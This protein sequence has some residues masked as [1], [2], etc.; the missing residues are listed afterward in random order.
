MQV[1][2]GVGEVIVAGGVESMSNAPF[3]STEMRWGTRGSGVTLHDGLAGRDYGISRTEQDQ[4][5]VRSH[6]RAVAAQRSGVF[7]QEIVPVTITSRKGETV[8]DTDEHPRADTTLETLGGLRPV[9][10]RQ[11]AEATVTAGKSGQNDAAEMCV[12]TQPERAEALGL[13]PLVRL[14]GRCRCSSLVSVRVRFAF[15]STANFGHPDG[16]PR[17]AISFVVA[18]FGYAGAGR[19]Q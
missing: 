3:F 17:P 12:V 4:L 8:V 1:A 10:G 11:D 18:V 6:E 14:V 7:A 16:L 9:L 13:R 2:T 5:A 19:G 15:R